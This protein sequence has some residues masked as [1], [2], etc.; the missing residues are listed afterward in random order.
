M[1]D[2]F[3]QIIADINRLRSYYGTRADVYWPVYEAILDADKAIWNA[4]HQDRLIRN[5]TTKEK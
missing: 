1:E 2:L 5:T 3:N 4:R